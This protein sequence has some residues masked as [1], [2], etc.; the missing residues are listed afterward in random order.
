MP[1]LYMRKE[2]EVGKR[3]P[4][5]ASGPGARR[6]RARCTRRPTRTPVSIVH[7]RVPAHT[8]PDAVHSTRLPHP[9]PSRPM[10]S[11]TSP[12]ATA[13]G[14]S[15]RPWSNRGGEAGR[16]AAGTS[17][18]DARR[19]SS[20]LITDGGALDAWCAPITRVGSS[21]KLLHRESVTR[22]RE[23][24]VPPPLLLRTYAG[25]RPS[26]RR[27]RRRGD[28]HR[29]RVAPPRP[30]RTLPRTAKPG[31]SVVPRAPSVDDVTSLRRAE[32]RG[33]DLGRRGADT[34]SARVDRERWWR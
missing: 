9:S 33:D 15:P 10:E 2:T 20:R 12:S 17:D 24:H 31:S 28:T 1:R 11:P 4:S 29:P 23:L 18:I 19:V 5:R 21:S 32:R 6:A 34:R 30:A 3:P 27:A 13:G 22:T 25:Y 26:P 14:T 8:P 16:D 7:P